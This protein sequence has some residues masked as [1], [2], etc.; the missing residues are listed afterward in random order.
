MTH[1]NQFVV[2]NELSKP[3]FLNIE[4]EGALFPLPH[5][6]EVVVS[7]TFTSA[8][9]TLKLSNSAKGETIVSI[10]PGDGQIRV[11]KDGEDV[12]EL[13]EKTVNV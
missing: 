5:G 12:L 11:A 9:V 6:E 2:C 1:R 3:L 7:E 4:P 8:P 13:I 10:W